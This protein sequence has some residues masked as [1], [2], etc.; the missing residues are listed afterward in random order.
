MTLIFSLKW[1][2]RQFLSKSFWKN[3]YQNLEK[4]QEPSV[5]VLIYAKLQLRRNVFPTI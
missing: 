3:Y 1:Q 5:L 4:I 2:R